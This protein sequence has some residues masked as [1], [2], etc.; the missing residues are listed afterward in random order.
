YEFGALELIRQ[1]SKVKRRSYIKERCKL[2]RPDDRDPVLEVEQHLG[3]AA[4]KSRELDNRSID[5]VLNEETVQYARSNAVSGRLR[6]LSD[7]ERFTADDI[8]GVNILSG[9]RRLNRSRR[10]DAPDVV[11]ANILFASKEEARE[12]R[13]PTHER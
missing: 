3:V 9:E 13:C 6:W 7:P 11:P 2:K 12:K 10:R 8:D 5:L 4:D 1:S